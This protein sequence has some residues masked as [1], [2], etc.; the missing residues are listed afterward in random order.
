MGD[1]FFTGCLNRLF[2]QLVT[3]F[4]AATVLVE[5]DVFEMTEVTGL[6]AHLELLFIGFVLVTGG[7]VE[8]LAFDLFL[9]IQMRFM[10]K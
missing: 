8:L 1:G 6:L 9:C 2:R 10:N 4:T 3:E 5:L 7:A